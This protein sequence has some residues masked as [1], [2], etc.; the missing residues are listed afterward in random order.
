MRRND[1]LFQASLLQREILTKGTETLTVDLSNDPRWDRSR[2]NEIEVY[3]YNREGYLRSGSKGY[4]AGRLAGGASDASAGRRGSLG[5]LESTTEVRPGDHTGAP[6]AR[7]WGVVAGVAGYQ[8][9]GLRLRYADD[10]AKG[11]RD[12]LMAI[13]ET[14]HSM[15]GVA[16]KP[17]IHLLTSSQPSSPSLAREFSTP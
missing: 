4:L 10:D 15:H 8:G 3:A 6:E 5:L 11:F 16:S 7:I 14:F 9:E 2:E 1:E 17:V 13:G 12:V